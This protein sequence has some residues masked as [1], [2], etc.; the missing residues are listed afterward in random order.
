MAGTRTHAAAEARHL[1]RRL[2]YHVTRGR[3]RRAS[4]I[5][6]VLLYRQ[7]DFLEQVVNTGLQVL[8]RAGDDYGQTKRFYQIAAA[9][10]KPQVCRFSTWPLRRVACPPLP[11]KPQLPF[12]WLAH[13]HG[14]PRL[15]QGLKLELE[16]AVFM[17][18]HGDL[19]EAVNA[20]ERCLCMEPMPLLESRCITPHFLRN[21]V[22]VTTIQRAV[23]LLT[24][25]VN[26]PNPPAM[27]VLALN[28]VYIEAGDAS[29]AATVLTQ[30]IERDPT[31]P[32]YHEYVKRR[33]SAKRIPKPTLISGLLDC[34][35]LFLAQ[36]RLGTSGLRLLPATR[37]HG[38]LFAP[39]ST[40]INGTPSAVIAVAFGTGLSHVQC[41]NSMLP[42]R[43][44]AHDVDM[45]VEDLEDA[46]G[47]SDEV[48]WWRERLDWWQDVYFSARHLPDQ[49]SAAL[50]AVL[51]ARSILVQMLGPT[52]LKEGEDFV[53]LVAS[54]M[55][56]HRHRVRTKLE[57]CHALLE[58]QSPSQELWQTYLTRMSECSCA[59][60]ASQYLVPSLSPTPL[61]RNNRPES[62]SATNASLLTASA[63]AGVSQASQLG[64]YSLSVGP[65]LD[66]ADDPM[67][68]FV[69]PSR[70][71]QS[72]RTLPPTDEA[73]SEEDWTKALSSDED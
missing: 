56:D 36:K 26:G 3:W 24:I 58:A 69:T 29:A 59:W 61:S 10:L 45:G 18:R 7:G 49:L 28:Q 19:A 67:N 22:I 5:I 21:Y 48:P 35:P 42:G 30:A 60:P 32:L 20:L 73:E 44:E 23:H 4:R 37:L 34:S 55:V 17:L 40:E 13:I 71:P 25:V 57:A 50:V 31:C 72:Q 33:V 63:V 27:A 65:T 38:M 41:G 8:Q 47:M 1:L 66:F 14:L 62:A 54:A 12:T 70:L 9:I 11:D 39:C 2:K 15:D 16:L 68:P 46:D 52:T 53:E 51:P 6:S 64:G 43:P